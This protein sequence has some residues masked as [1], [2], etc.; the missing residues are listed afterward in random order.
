MRP[1]IKESLVAHTTLNNSKIIVKS[2]TISMKKIK[3]DQKVRDTIRKLFI[4]L[5]LINLMIQQHINL[6]IRFKIHLGLV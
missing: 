2:E 1:L 4:S 5:S 6:I 3:K